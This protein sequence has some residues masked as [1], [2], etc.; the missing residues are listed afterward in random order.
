MND[1]LVSCVVHVLLC[2][3]QQ[4]HPQTPQPGHLT[5][6]L[7]TMTSFRLRWTLPC[8]ASSESISHER[9]QTHEPSPTTISNSKLPL[10]TASQSSKRNSKSQ[11]P[12]SCLPSKPT[13]LRPQPRLGSNPSRY[14][15]PPTQERMNKKKNMKP[16]PET[17]PPSQQPP[18]HHPTLIRTSLKERPRIPSKARQAIKHQVQA[19]PRPCS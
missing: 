17:K 3:H 10:H 9:S 13:T 5:R 12:N 2:A 1:S 6:P 14:G 4:P 7:P 11:P 8:V 15:S 18:T 16:R 19:R